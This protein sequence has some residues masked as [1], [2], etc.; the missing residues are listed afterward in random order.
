MWL[1]SP[2]G[3]R[4]PSLH[5]SSEKWATEVDGDLTE[6]GW[7]FCVRRLTFVGCYHGPG[8]P[9][10][11]MNDSILEKQGPH[12][13]RAKVGFIITTSKSIKWQVGSHLLQW[14]IDYDAPKS[15]G[16]DERFSGDTV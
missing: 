1:R 15:N 7:L 5:Q 8:L 3:Y 6:K 16:V 2:G 14:L 11:F 13:V 10:I 9:G 12:G 4:G